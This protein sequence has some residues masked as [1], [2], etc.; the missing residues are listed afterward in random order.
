MSPLFSPSGLVYRYVLAEPGSQPAGA[1]DHPG[2]GRGA[3][4]QIRAGSCGRFGTRRHGHAVSGPARS[5]RDIFGYHLTVP[6]GRRRRWP[7]TIRMPEGASILRAG[8]SI[9]CAGLG[10]IRDTDDIGDIIVGAQ[11]TG[12]RCASATSATSRSGMLRAWANSASR[13]TNDD[14]VEGVILMRRG[15]QTQNVLQAVREEDGGAEPAHPAA[16]RQSPAVL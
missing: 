15:E 10:L 8:S 16:G 5:P 14:A 11:R 2:L 4:L 9:T 12:P 13:Q 6:A 7:P 3:R 1:E